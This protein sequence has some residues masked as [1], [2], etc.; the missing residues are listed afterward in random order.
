MPP[1][2]LLMISTN[3]V[4]YIPDITSYLGAVFDDP[5][6]D[7]VRRC[8]Y[9]F[10]LF[11]DPTK[12]KEH[13][14]RGECYLSCPIPTRIN[15][16]E[17]GD[18]IE[19][20][21][22]LDILPR[23]CVCVLDIECNVIGP[24]IQTPPPG[25]GSE[26][27]YQPL[28]KSITN[29]SV[30][31]GNISHIHV[32][33]SIGLCYLDK[34]H[35][36]LSHNVY[37]DDDIESQFP[38]IIVRE[39]K[40]HLD[41][42][43]SQRV[44]ICYMTDDDTTRHEL[45]EMCAICETLFCILPNWF[46]HAD[47]CHYTLPVF[48][49]VSGN[50]LMGNYRQALCRSCNMKLTE[51]RDT[52]TVIAHN[53]S[54]YDFP[55]LFKGFVENVENLKSIKVIPKGAHSYYRVQFENIDFIDSLSFIPGSLGSL[56]ELK[57]KNIENEGV[58][59]AVP[60]TAQMTRSEYC[61]EMLAYIGRK[62]IF[63]YTL[64]S[65]VRA[66][67]SIKDWPSRDD[68]FNDLSRE[69]VSDHDYEFGLRV[70]TSL[71]KHVGSENMNL[72]VLHKWYLYCDIMLLADIWSWFS[73]VTKEKFDVYPS[74]YITGPA[75]S[76][77]AALKMGKTEL[78]KLVN[79]QMYSHMESLLR[80][81]FCGVSK[82][83]IRANN[84]EMGELYNPSLID[85]I[86]LILDW[87]QLY[88]CLLK[89]PIPYANFN[90]LQFEDPI[91]REHILGI[92]PTGEQGYIFIV[93]IVIPEHLKLLYDDLPL[94]LILV[95]KIKPSG[96]TC[97]LLE[98]SNSKPQGKRLV[99]GHFSLC[100]YGFHVRLLQFY[101]QIGCEL[102]KI[103]DIIV[104]D[105]KPVFKPFIEVC[106]TQ[107]EI[108]RDIPILNKL[109]K[110]M[111]NSLYGRTI[112]NTRKYNTNTILVRNKTL[113]RHLNNPRCQK[114]RL[115]GKNCF[116]VTKSKY[117]VTLE[118]PI[119]IGAVILQLAKLRNFRFHYFLAKPSG[120]DFSLEQFEQVIKNFITPEEYKMVLKS[121]AVIK[122]VTLAYT[123]TDSLHYEVVMNKTGMTFND[124]VSDYV[125]SLHMD[126][127]N[128]KVLDGNP[129]TFDSGRDELFK[130]EISDSIAV[131]GVYV[132]SKCY[133]IKVLARQ[134]LNS[135][136]TTV[137]PEQVPVFKYKKTMKSCPSSLL[138]KNF[139]HDYYKEVVNEGIVLNAKPVETTHIKFNEKIG[140]HTT[141]KLKRRPMT[142]IDIKRCY[143]T[144]L[145]SY[146][147]EH[148][149][150]F[151][152]GY[153]V[154]DILS[155]KGGYILGT[156]HLIN[157]QDVGKF[158]S[159]TG[160]ENIME[161]VVEIGN[162]GDD[163]AVSDVVLGEEGSNPIADTLDVAMRISGIN[164]G[165]PLDMLVSL[166]EESN[167]ILFRGEDDE[168]SE[169]EVEEDVVLP[170]KR[171]RL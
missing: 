87:S 59:I 45:T 107:R 28:F 113:S 160:D 31:A 154:G 171:R 57:C 106:V 118:A 72:L 164:E 96:Y 75:M 162:D 155:T 19:F 80:G 33:V 159:V 44:P 58:D 145:V 55:A 112:L 51:K 142:A 114:K 23:E 130:S 40:K 129:S 46:K 84:I 68:F 102:T 37:I 167:V 97:D 4:A 56:V 121:R 42:I 38:N 74:N 47:H 25:E 151:G 139:S 125:F 81:G 86:I 85:S 39:T 63:P 93:D 166:M 76:Y 123:D 163:V 120:S 29:E 105:Q 111:G 131:E 115:V 27:N 136:L 21:K 73:K 169:N 53:M 168:L 128:F 137:T 132:S 91:S 69:A 161:S 60:L 117:S 18:Y 104:F 148:P 48:D 49:D 138:D 83:L 15:L 95:D 103:H 99:A 78:E 54:F 7:R 13:Y 1:C 43:R 20:I 89:E 116:L 41:I 65:S 119:Y 5:L 61:T 134:P 70:W 153:K 98:D 52:V 22:K 109:F 64:C 10:A 149:K 11:P 14:V 35:N 9:C 3:H 141:T 66:M 50:L 156:E 150:S 82:R 143:E 24:T 101:L 26:L 92:D 122:S 126:R 16:P 94:G 8:K 36:I 110:L 152:L 12:L 108:H 135:T 6:P 133:S 158:N 34:D 88:S 71:K 62:Q 147:Y 144:P 30:P 170:H 17:P 127:S 2:H 77:A 146:G 32:P 90:Y 157:I 140:R 124:L 100:Q 79:P 165:E 67:E